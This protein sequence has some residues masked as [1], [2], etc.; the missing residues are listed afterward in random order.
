MSDKIKKQK[1][2]TLVEIAIVLVIVG[3]LIGMG[4][5]NSLPNTASFPSIVRKSED[6]WSNPLIYI[7]DNSLTGSVCGRTTTGLSVNDCS[8]DT[9][10]SFV[11]IN[12]VAYIILSESENFNN[13]TFASGPA[14]ATV[15]VYDFG[16]NVYNFAGDGTVVQPYDD[17]VKWITL[18]E[19][20]TKAD[21][22]D[23]RLKILNNELPS[24]KEVS[25]YNAT[26]FADGGVPF[27]DGAGDLDSVVD[28]EWCLEDDPINNLPGSISFTCVGQSLLS[29]AS[30]TLVTGTCEQCTTLGITAT[31]IAASTAGS[32]RPTFFV[33][34]ENDTIGTNDNITQKSLVITISP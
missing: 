19:L 13:Q 7:Y 12:N 30:C 15:N 34:D 17:I 24:G 8:D 11:A 25:A 9:C 10:T 4:A 31:P 21:C 16:L 23:A 27:A 14:S 29:A 32:Y 6:V 1:G 28:Y 33:R 18:S 5:S 26:L 20:T 3:L 2:F 22:S